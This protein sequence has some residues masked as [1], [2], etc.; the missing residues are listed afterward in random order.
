V[1]LQ[2]SLEEILSF[3]A[4][5]DDHRGGNRRTPRSPLD[6]MK[7]K[8]NFRGEQN[9]GGNNRYRERRELPIGD[10]EFMT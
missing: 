8:H 1:T 7:A 10:A 4:G 3:T 5:D 9:R 2:R 6:T